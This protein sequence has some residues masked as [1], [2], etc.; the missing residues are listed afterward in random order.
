MVTRKAGFY[1][2]GIRGLTV[3]QAFLNRFGPQAIAFVVIDGDANLTDDFSSDIAAFCEEHEVH[4]LLRQASTE[5]SLPTHD[6]AYAIGWRY[7]LPTSAHLVIL[8]DSPLPRF[9][10]FSPVPNMLINGETILGVTALLAQEDYDCGDILAQE[11][12]EITYPIKVDQAQAQLRPLYVQLV[13]ELFD[14]VCDTGELPAGVPQSEAL[15]T[16]SPWRDGDD[17]AINWHWPAERIAR[18]C[19]AVGPPFAGALATTASRSYR[20][21]SAEAIADVTV[22]SREDHIGKILFMREGCPVVICAQGLLLIREIH[23]DDDKHQSKPLPFRTRF[24]S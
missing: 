23:R 12:T 4:V 1:V 21:L 14:K 18:F 6:V 3:L 22:E 17:Y 5:Q 13:C 11:F 15:A 16:Y 20:V 9:R 8:H 7:L 19:D 2:L 24:L 10:G